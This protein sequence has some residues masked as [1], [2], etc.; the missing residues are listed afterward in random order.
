MKID[1][2]EL[3]PA[4]ISSEAAFH[5]V[6]FTRDLGLALE[7]VYFEKMLEYS[8]ICEHDL[9]GTDEQDGLF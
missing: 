4:N 8:S 3:L 6:K 9:F 1:L 5:V 7:A 2:Q